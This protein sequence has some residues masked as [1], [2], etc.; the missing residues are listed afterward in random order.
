MMNS[1]EY[2]RVI[3]EP[4][5]HP[6][7]KSMPIDASTQVHFIQRLQREGRLSLDA[8]YDIFF[9]TPKS[10]NPQT[11]RTLL[12]GHY[13]DGETGELIV[14]AR[15]NSQSVSLLDEAVLANPKD[16]DVVYNGCAWTETNYYAHL[17]SRLVPEQTNEIGTYAHGTIYEGRSAQPPLTRRLGAVISDDDTFLRS[18]GRYGAY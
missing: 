11:L 13:G 14:V 9:K 3:E 5:S 12:L 15:T 17:G 10:R 18:K 6:Q 7:A 4:G 16:Y 2:D 8:V 1:V